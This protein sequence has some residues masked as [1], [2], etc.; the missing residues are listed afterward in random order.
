MTED[1]QSVIRDVD[2][3]EVGLFV[4][5]RDGDGGGE[6]ISGSGSGV[7]AESGMG[8]GMSESGVGGGG[9][10]ERINVVEA[11]PL[12]E[13]KKRVLKMKVKRD[14]EEYEPEVYAEAALRFLAK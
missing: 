10:V 7:G 4:M 13:R 11:T 8:M 9:E 6:G 2:E 14:V 3:T 12:R 5:K 1:I